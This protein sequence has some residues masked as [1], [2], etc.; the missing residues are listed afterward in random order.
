MC[1]QKLMRDYKAQ[2]VTTLQTDAHFIDEF[3]HSESL[4]NLL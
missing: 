2:E 1:V 3:V 4:N